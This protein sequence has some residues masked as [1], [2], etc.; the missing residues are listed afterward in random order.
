MLIVHAV[1]ENR[2]GRRDGRPHARGKCQSSVG[3]CLPNHSRGQREVLQRPRSWMGDP[4]QVSGRESAVVKKW[5]RNGLR[6]N[7]CNQQ[8][9]LCTCFA[10]RLTTCLRMFV[11]LRG[12]PLL[13]RWHCFLS[14]QSLLSSITSG[15]SLAVFNN[16][17]YFAFVMFLKLS[18]SLYPD[19]NDVIRRCT[20]ALHAS[21]HA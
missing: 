11:R 13:P 21:M 6:A 18:L 16:R 14:D 19:V 15:I 7:V 9:S 5:G 1:R 2:Y 10:L 4:K 3:Y 17:H 20:S 12:F 8:S